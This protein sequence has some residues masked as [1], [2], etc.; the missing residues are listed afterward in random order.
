M[1]TVSVIPNISISI[2]NEVRNFSSCFTKKHKNHLANLR[3]IFKGSILQSESYLTSIGKNMSSETATRTLCTAFSNTLG[4]MNR[5]TLQNIHL[6]KEGKNFSSEKTFL[7]IDGGD[8]QK[9]HSKIEPRASEEVFGEHYVRENDKNY[10]LEK[11]CGN[12]DGDKGHSVGKGYYLEG[13]VGYGARSKKI[14]PLNLHLYSTEEDSFK[15]QFDEQKKGLNLVSENFAPSNFDR[16]V[17]EDRG[18]DS[19]VKYE[20]YLKNSP[21]SFLTRMNSNG[22]SRQMIDAESG[23]VI[24]V[25]DIASRAKREGKTGDEKEWINKHSKHPDFKNKKITSEIG[26]KKVFLKE[27]PEIPLHIIF[28]WSDTYTEPLIL[29]TDQNISSKTEAWNYF[30]VYRKRWEIEKMYR[31]LKQDFGLE[32][33]RV[34]SLQKQKTLAFLLMY[35]WNFSKN[36]YKK[37][38][39]ILGFGIRVFEI[40]V[41]KHQKQDDSFA[42]LSFL[43]AVIYPLSQT[44][45]HRDFSKKFSVLRL[46]PSEDQLEL[47]ELKR[48]P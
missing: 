47:F 18:G 8:I 45:S 11:I 35:I 29:L 14:S 33:M 30:F 41:K 5:E 24:S 43:R 27:F 46:P 15:S 38:S 39:Q 36:L 17:V 26:Y 16:V 3:E 7:F 4:K 28:V 13:I 12:R 6:K 20:W 19:V 21:F 22:R 31:E 40:F 34:R 37:K 32:K 9:K 44:Y 10:P 1:E 23:E 42:F 25:V 48:I 2:F